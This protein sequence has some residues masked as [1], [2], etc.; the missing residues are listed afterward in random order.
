MVG[1]TGFEP[2]TLCS[3]I[4]CRI[5]VIGSPA[6]DLLVDHA[7]ALKEARMKFAVIIFA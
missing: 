6:A 3:Q 7:T 1:E 4:N 5:D 2:A